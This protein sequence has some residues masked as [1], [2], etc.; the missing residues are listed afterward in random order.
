MSWISKEHLLSGLTLLSGLS[1]VVV[2]L[3]DR[4]ILF[5]ILLMLTIVLLIWQRASSRESPAK[6]KAY[7]V[8][9][10]IA[11][12]ASNEPVEKTWIDCAYCQG[13]GTLTTYYDGQTTRKEKCGIC[14]G[15]GQ[16][17]TEL[18]NR[19]AC[20][21]CEGTGRLVSKEYI[22]TLHNLGYRIVQHHQF[23][24]EI[25]PCDVCNGTGKRPW[26]SGET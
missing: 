9:P 6:T 15:H 21:R 20:R 17:L 23:N 22:P 25:Q 24:T 1:S 12:P 10:A 5:F 11:Q 26:Q 19:P 2:L 18:W 8:E 4:P 14:Q 13:S 16:I 7:P 3:L